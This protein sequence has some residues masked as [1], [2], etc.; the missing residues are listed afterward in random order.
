MLPAPC[1]ARPSRS[2]FSS[3][4]LARI[5]KAMDFDKPQWYR[6]RKQ[7]DAL[8]IH[9]SWRGVVDDD[10]EPITSAE[11]N[12]FRMG[13]TDAEKKWRDVLRRKR[14]CA[15]KNHKCALV[16]EGK[17]DDRCKHVVGS[18]D[19]KRQQQQSL[20]CEK[21]PGADMSQD[22]ESDNSSFRS[23][24]ESTPASAT[25]SSTSNLPA[26]SEQSGTSSDPSS[27]ASTDLLPKPRDPMGPPSPK[28]GR[29][30][31]RAPVRTQGAQATNA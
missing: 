16:S 25:S 13:Y 3:L 2:R 5:T 21:V 19:Y 12:E 7:A 20:K 22:S 26:S 23:E 4:D 1:V 18:G 17:H 29:I 28:R 6:K 10:G 9:P 14:P 30:V 31:S 27:A 15:V 11:V 8:P 24:P